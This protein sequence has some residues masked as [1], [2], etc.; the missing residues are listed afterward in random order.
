MLGR[1]IWCK[2]ATKETDYRLQATAEGV[3]KTRAVRRWTNGTEVVLTRDQLLPFARKNGKISVG[4]AIAALGHAFV[5]IQREC[6]RHGL[7]VSRTAVSQAICLETLSQVLGGAPY[8]TEWNDGTFINPKTGGRFRFDG[9]FPAQKLLVEFQGAQH[10]D[11]SAKWFFEGG[12][13]YEEYI[14]RDRQKALQVEAD[15]RF[16]LFLVRENEPYT[17]LGY[18]RGRLIDEGCLDP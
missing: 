4:K 15:G 2:G 16:K 14:E 9:F 1:T 6:A 11:P 7:K 3:S 5:I 10:Y 18:L 17:D 8:E 13:T 12:A